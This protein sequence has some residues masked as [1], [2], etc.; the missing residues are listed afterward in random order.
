MKNRHSKKT[1]YILLSIFIFTHTVF[2]TGCN[3]GSSDNAVIARVENSVL[4]NRELNRRIIWKGLGEEQKRKYIEEW[5]NR[6]LLYK[7]AL[8][9]NLDKTPDL[10]LEIEQVK[11]E[12]LINRLV[13][14]IFAEK[15]KITDREIESYYNKNQNLFRATDD[16]RWVLHLL[17][18]TRSN[19]REAM[20]EINAG[21]DFKEVARKYSIGIFKNNN[22]DLGY[23]K[24]EDVIDEISRTAF[25]LNE[26]EVSG[27]IHTKYGYH[28]VKVL[29]IREEG[30]IEKLEQVSNEII[31]RLRIS[32]EKALYYDLLAELQNKYKIYINII[33]DKNN[34]EVTST[35]PRNYQ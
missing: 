27:I 24:E 7:E 15:I 17:T 8:Q 16:E 1:V 23:I 9:Q 10:E 33:E 20:Q 18:D 5:V 26:N 35:L 11:K 32:K 6:E 29:D 31:Q 30:E 19:A 12:F 34:T 25:N 14:K 22:G 21:K 13:D 2:N 4:T 3:N 28:I